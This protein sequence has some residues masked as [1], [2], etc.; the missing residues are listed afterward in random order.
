MS[1]DPNRIP[2]LVGIGQS[3]ERDGV[4]NVVDLAARAA[5]TAFEDAPGIR[6]RVQRVTMVGVSF[7]PV[8]L[9]PASEVADRLGLTKA[10]RE[11]STPGGNSPQWLMSRACAEIAAGSLETTLIVGA[12]ATRSMR[13]ADPGSDFLRAATQDRSA[14]EGPRDAVVGASIRG[15]LGKA[16]VDAALLRPADTYPVFESALAA[17]LGATAEQSRERI[18]AFMSRS[19]EVAAKNPMAWFQK[20]RSAQ[21]IAEPSPK[22]RITAEPYTK[23]MNSF[24]NVDQGSALLVTTLAVAQEAG[25]ADQC[26][27]PW[28]GAN[29][30]ELVPSARP[31][32][33]GSPAIRAAGKATFAAAGVGLD[34]IDYIDLYSCFPVAVEI[35][36]AEIGLALDDPRGLTQTGGM[37]FFGGP[38]NNYVS[39]GIAAVA[40][41]LRE[42]GAS[43]RLGYASGNGGILSKHS[44]GIYG[45]E[46]PSQG[47]RLADTSA[48]QDAIA[49]SA[50]EVVHEAEGEAVVDGG[51]VVYDR[52]GQP[53]S[54][55]VIA[56]LA[57]GKR[58]VA[59]ASPTTLPTLTGRSL[60]GERIQV[61][62]AN[63]PVYSV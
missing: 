11:T 44:L 57:D 24:A 50:L 7:S 23:C 53:A 29:N 51:T 61:T 39:H 28:S 31:D 27:F 54:A 36:A 12:E 42:A 52:E 5:E 41:R 21:D 60:V 59:I 40:L 1:P 17:K 63:P 16:E 30:A 13:L 49:A 18:A 55:P 35:G 43:G 4:V 6:D 47:F 26:V 48:E 62:G 3:I 33:G 37:S 8:S 2:V 56:T 34:E 9:A 22:N 25:L 20:V 10:E 15:M 46:P 32:L 58:I 14:E 19:S 45:S 38:G